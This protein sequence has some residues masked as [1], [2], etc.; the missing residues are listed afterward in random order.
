MWSWLD[1]LADLTESQFMRGVDALVSW[2]KDFPP[3]IGQF[4]ALC[5]ESPPA[6]HQPFAPEPN[7]PLLERFAG[8]ALTEIGRRELDKCQRIAAGRTDDPDLPTREQAIHG[9]RL[10]A[11]W[12]SSGWK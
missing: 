6:Y 9:C 8:K 2:V 1:D 11:W 12:G 5:L 4:R 7:M 10:H 3:T